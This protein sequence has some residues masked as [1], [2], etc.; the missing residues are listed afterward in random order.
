MLSGKHKSS[1]AGR[2][3]F[4]L[5]LV[6]G[7]LGF[8]TSR[9]AMGQAVSKKND[10]FVVQ[11]DE[12][13][14]LRASVGKVLISAFP[15]DVDIVRSNNER[16][17]YVESITVKEDGEE[18][19]RAE[20]ANI[21]VIVYQTRGKIEFQ[22]RGDIGGNR[23]IKLWIPV[24]L[25]LEISNSYGDVTVE[26]GNAP[27]EIATGTGDIIISDLEGYLDIW[28]GMGDVDVRNVS[29]PLTIES[30]AGDVEAVHIGAEIHILTGA[31]DIE[32]SNIEGDVTTTTGG[33]DIEGDRINGDVDSFTGG[34][35][36]EF[37]Y[38]KGDLDLN[39]SGGTIE[40]E[41]IVGHV[42]AT[43]SGGDIDVRQLRGSLTA[44]TMAGDVYVYDMSG[45]VKVVSK[46]GDVFV[47][48]NPDRNVELEFIDI[49]AENGDIDLRIP[50]DLKADLR[51]DL[52][53]Y[54]EL[55][56]D[57]FGGHLEW[58]EPRR[59]SAGARIRRAVGTLNKGGIRI[60]LST[61][62]GDIS[63]KDR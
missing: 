15:G 43:T 29:G 4:L 39:T 36:I 40:F 46:V 26:G 49:R 31:G 12:T 41:Y 23:R 62:T 48:I 57:K 53:Y 5:L 54:G 1:L 61:G 8:A 10:G 22:S 34:G 13:V 2:T 21:S 32:I 47:R 37:V 14:Q 27:V 59:D 17:R 3:T 6:T 51:I 33:G 9:V 30:G 42:R 55:E 24:D 50:S 18:D 35:N 44:E 52:G 28:T 20:A 25:E 7:L 19:A 63:I 45:D 16:I 56:T 38:V 11:F 60:E 58:S